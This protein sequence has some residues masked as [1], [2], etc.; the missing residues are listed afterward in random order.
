MMIRF[1]DIPYVG[2]TVWALIAIAMKHGDVNMLRNLATFLAL[3]L[4]S[5]TIIRSSRTDN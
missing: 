3:A 4:I 1:N 2:V 5:I